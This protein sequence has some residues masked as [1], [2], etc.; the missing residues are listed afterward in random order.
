MDD[1]KI[2]FPEDIFIITGMSDNDWQKQTTEDMFSCIKGNVYH[3]GKI[4]EFHKIIENKRNTKILIII[5]ECQIATTKNLQIDKIIKDLECQA[6]EK[7][8]NIKYL[9]VSATPSVIKY[10]LD[11]CGTNHKLVIVEPSEKY[12]SFQTFINEDRL[13]E[14]DE[15][16]YEFLD[17]NFLPLL[18]EIFI[19]PK[20]HIIRLSEKKRS[21]FVNW[22]KKYNYIVVCL[23]SKH[24][25]QTN[26]LIE[27]PIHHTFIIIKG[28][29]RAG[30]RMKDKHVGIVYEYN[31]NKDIDI[32]AQG[33]VARF[34][35]NDKLMNTKVSPRLFCKIDT[36]KEYI[37]F[38]NKE[39]NFHF[40]NYTSNKIKVTDGEVI[41]SKET[42]ISN[43]NTFVND[44]N[45]LIEKKDY[46]D[47]PI[48]IN[49]ESIFDK[50]VNKNNNKYEVLINAE[51][52]LLQFLSIN[53]DNIEI[54]NKIINNKMIKAKITVPDP[55]NK[56]N[57][58]RHIIDTRSCIN[59]NAVC[60]TDI[61]DKKYKYKNVWV[62]FIDINQK[63][64][65]LILYYGERRNNNI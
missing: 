62:G 16:S 46:I 8:I 50:I 15:L 32:T 41:K 33:L 64:I 19:K 36:I 34:C 55:D 12:V 53:Q 47:I 54:Y 29:W 57:Y 21:I 45:R 44:K 5:D 13:C 3:L 9:V 51:N 28:Y 14:A 56:D 38:I 1:S 30:K 58:K 25:V 61:N 18:K 2:Y 42:I 35:G 60:K 39:C 43:L 31:P 17:N 63:S 40:A 4:K 10:D 11:K 27:E 22:C 7:N 49:I 37:N 52:I 20:Y 26:L 24:P 59:R 6:D 48:E 65:L 23:D